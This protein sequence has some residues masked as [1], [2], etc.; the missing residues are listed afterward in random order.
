MS[1]GLIIILLYVVLLND[2]IMYVF[3]LNIILLSVFLLDVAAPNDFRYKQS[4]VVTLPRH[5]SLR[6]EPE[7]CRK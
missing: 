2:I 5:L 4:L 7:P 6:I 1:F 3:L